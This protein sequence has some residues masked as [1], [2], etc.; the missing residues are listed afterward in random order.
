MINYKIESES[1]SKPM[2]KYIL[3]FIYEDRTTSKPTRI[4]V[5]EF[6]VPKRRLVYDENGIANS[7]TTYVRPY[8]KIKNYYKQLLKNYE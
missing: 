6:I 2:W 4:T 3:N 7:W 1:W 8:Y 5:D